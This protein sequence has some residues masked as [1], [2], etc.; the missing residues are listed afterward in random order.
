MK[1]FG[2]KIKRT[3]DPRFLR[4]DAK[5]I[6]DIDFPGMLHMAI[7]RSPHGHA[8]VKRIDP[9]AALKVP[10]VVR[11]VTADDLGDMMPLPCVWV[12]GGVESHFPPHPTGLPA[13]NPVL[14][15][16]KVRYI[17]DAIAAVVAETR[18][19]A[20][21]ALDAIHV[22]YELLPVVTTPKEAIEDGAPQL[23]EAVPNNLN[24]YWTCG[25]ED[26][27]DRA[28]SE[29]DVVVSQSMLNQRT[30]NSP[31][32]PR[33]AIGTYDPAT[34]EYT[35]YASTQN[36]YNHRMLLAFA[37]LGVPFNKVRV[38]SP[39]IGGSFGTK[40]YLYSDMALVMYLSKELGRPVKWVDTRE[41]LMRST[42]Q[43]RDQHIHG[44][45]AGKRD[46]TITAMRCTSYANLGAYPSTIG[47]GVVTA[48]M[49]R[50]MT[51]CYAIPHA[52]CEVYAAFTNVV[53]LGAQR[54][55]GRAEA[56]FLVE[57]LVER[58]AAEIGMDPVE[59]RRKN[60]VQ[61]E[62][63][64]FDNG[65]GWMYDSG[66]YPAALEKAMEMADY[67]NMA[68][69]KAG[70]RRRGKRL[71]MGIGC[72]VAVSGVGPSPRMAKEG[73]QGGAWETANVRLQPTGDVSVTIGAVPHGQSHETVFAQIAAEELQVDV[74]RIEV[75][76]GDTRSAPFGQGSYGSRSLSVGG[77]AVHIAAAQIRE[78]VIKLAAHMLEADEQDIV[79][80][81][82]KA[83]VRGSPD[84]SKALEEIALAGFYGWDLPKGMEPNW[85]VT[86]FF[87]PPEFNFP[88]GA[89][90]AT[91]EIDER[92]GEI[93]L[94]NF[95]AV[96]DVGEV[97]NPMV[98][99]G[100]VHGGITHGVGQALFERAIYDDQGHLMTANLTE[101]AIPRATDLPEFNIDRTV[102]PTQHNPLGAKGAGEIGAVGAAAA[103][104]N[105]VVDALS[106]LGVKHVDMPYT[107]EK[108]WRILQENGHRAPD[109]SNGGGA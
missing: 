105:A 109:R 9:S 32:E 71:G 99:N 56:T 29:A 83:W 17:G 15:K 100:Q 92:T 84:N 75:L 107:P 103:I 66:N 11:V 5:F 59:V 20:H 18:A 3:E 16:D 53:P 49:G 38:I 60:F 65:L 41:G 80:E 52:F 33:G 68:A 90:V 98:I 35:L 31:I 96:T 67:A 1:V 101:Y 63:F 74:S 106:D 91:V 82:G 36:I 21:D 102:T 44:T 61:P 2:E 97:A 51:G 55:S 58:F 108:L 76:H 27:T 14:S 87:D 26:A 47:P 43:G 19:Q 64:P 24:A 54:G 94:V 70:A 77:P 42:V 30:I 50:S 37:V 62:Q 93:D 34:E 40:G 81:D 4:G 23:H 86:T 48:M 89:H 88:Y 73:L 6:A 25:D 85:D 45:L 95:A 8:L 7:L 39:D 22:D 72:F 46:G 28:I 78:K 57:R 10:G 12:P 69:L 104:G 13:S 79:Y